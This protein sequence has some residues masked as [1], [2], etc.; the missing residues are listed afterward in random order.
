MSDR[1]PLAQLRPS[2]LYTYR[3]REGRTRIVSS[4]D[5]DRLELGCD[6][7]WDEIEAILAR[8]AELEKLCGSRTPREEEELHELWARYLLLRAYSNYYREIVRRD[9]LRAQGLRPEPT[10]LEPRIRR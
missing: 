9:A 3:T 5:P 1:Q 6:K 2:G 8:H 4:P 7:I 10:L